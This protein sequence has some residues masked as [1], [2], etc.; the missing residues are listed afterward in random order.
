[1]WEIFVVSSIVAGLWLALTLVGFAGK[2][3]LAPIRVFAWVPLWLPL[4]ML[5]I[6]VWLL[7]RGGRRADPATASRPSR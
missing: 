3:L 6:V 7:A 4:S 2:L 1:M 5:G